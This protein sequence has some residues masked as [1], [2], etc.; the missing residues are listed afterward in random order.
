MTDNLS[1]AERSRVMSRVKSAD[2]MPEMAIRR[3]IYR[4]GYRY[5]LHAA[6]LPGRPDIV[7]RNKKKVIFVH[8]CFWHRHRCRNGRRLPKSHRRFWRRKLEKNAV[9]DK[10]CLIALRRMGY[11][12]LII[13]ECQVQRICG[14]E[15]CHEL[16]KFLR[17]P[18]RCPKRR[19]PASSTGQN[20]IIKC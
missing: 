4:L 13:W 15:G 16:R 11:T 12:S 3:L 2:T 7:F 5:R 18:S 8:G 1:S 6:G 19:K 20:A 14:N 17:T 9:R 10:R